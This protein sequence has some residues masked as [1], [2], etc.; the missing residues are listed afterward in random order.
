MDILKTI[1]SMQDL[2]ADGKGKTKEFVDLFSAYNE[3][4]TKLFNED[5][6]FDILTGKAITYPGAK[7]IHEMM[8]KYGVGNSATLV[9]VTQSL[10]ESM[11]AEEL[12]SALIQL[13]NG[14]SLDIVK[15]KCSLI[16]NVLLAQSNAIDIKEVLFTNSIALSTIMELEVI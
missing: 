7:I 10:Y 3:E 9:E 6:R 15:E 1:K 2:L 4:A 5:K 12:D 13:Y 16:L 8:S 14:A 11:S